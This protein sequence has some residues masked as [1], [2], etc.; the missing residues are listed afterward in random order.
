MP[1]PRGWQVARDT[2][3]AAAA[4]SA[5]AATPAATSGKSQMETTLQ[6]IWS[7]CLGIGSIDPNANFFELGGDSLIAISVAM[8]A[9]NEGLDLTPQDLYENQTVAAL[10][11]V[12]IA[13]YAEGGL[14]RQSLDDVVEPARSAQRCALPRARAA[15][16][17]PLA[18]SRWSCNCVPMSSVEDIR[19]VL[20]AVTNHH[21]ALRLRIVERAGTWDQ[22]VG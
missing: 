22:H 3:G 11:R 9:A 12:L 10:A 1:P 4:P 14:A 21:D 20:T 7:Q 6:R 17:R 5:A 15:R 13:R 19:S 2:N 8:T 18:D 16:R